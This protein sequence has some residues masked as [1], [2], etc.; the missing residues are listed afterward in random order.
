MAQ[1]EDYRKRH[2]IEILQKAEEKVRLEI[3]DRSERNDRSKTKSKQGHHI[4]NKG[5]IDIYQEI[6]LQFVRDYRHIFRGKTYDDL[7]TEMTFDGGEREASD[8]LFVNNPLSQ[9]SKKFIQE[10]KVHE[11]GW[12]YDSNNDLIFG[13]AK[14]NL[15]VRAS[16]LMI[17][18]YEVLDEERDNGLLP[19]LEEFRNNIDEHFFPQTEYAYVDQPALNEW[20]KERNRNYS[21]FYDIRSHIR[22][23]IE[24]VTHQRIEDETTPLVFHWGRG[25]FQLVKRSE[26]PDLT[27][28]T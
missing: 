25:A 2:V 10:T 13:L 23:M 7:K 22:I 21:K 17:N 8:F 20:K 19:L 18:M 14:F 28:G 12:N 11:N 9:E 26:A 1:T 4:I 27:C 16:Y 15:T 3:N 24:N 5:V 6:I